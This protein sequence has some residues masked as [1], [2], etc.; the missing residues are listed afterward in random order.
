MLT[1]LAA[2]AAASA[3][4]VTLGC[5]RAENDVAASEQIVREFVRS[6][7]QELRA[8]RRALRVLAHQAD[9]KPEA[10]VAA[11]SSIDALVREASSKLDAQAAAAV[12]RVEQLERISWQT[13]Q[14]RI[15]RIEE[16]LEELRGTLVDLAEEAKYELQASAQKAT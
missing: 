14:N 10:I 16:R 1:A 5:S 8:F 3:V 7:G 2:A 11:V 4:T 13:E 12:R 9:P 6:G 15:E